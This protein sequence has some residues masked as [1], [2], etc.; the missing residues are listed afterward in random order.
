MRDSFQKSNGLDSFF[1]S[2]KFNRSSKEKLL[3]DYIVNGIGKNLKFVPSYYYSQINL[4]FIEGQFCHC[5]VVQFVPTDLDNVRISNFF[6]I[7]E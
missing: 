3:K 4:S 5:Y 7:F 6:N 1:L 2:L